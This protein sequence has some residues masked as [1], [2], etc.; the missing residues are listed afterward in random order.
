MA[1][2]NDR[3][4]IRRRS[5]SCSL[6]LTSDVGVRSE[7][8]HPVHCLRLHTSYPC[9]LM[10][11]KLMTRGSCAVSSSDHSQ[12]ILSSSSTSKLKLQY[13]SLF[14]LSLTLVIAHSPGNGLDLSLTRTI[15]INLHISA[16][17]SNHHP[18]D[19]EYPW[20][21]M[22]TCGRS[23]GNANKSS[24]TLLSLPLDLRLEIYDWVFIPRRLRLGII[25]LLSRLSRR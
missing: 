12:L 13:C 15:G 25:G 2:W 16:A 21:I 24:T 5:P 23:E 18:R 11:Q 22:D 8:H 1:G 6:S 17:F 20:H 3:C 19:S 10:S 9:D 4:A 14:R 7:D